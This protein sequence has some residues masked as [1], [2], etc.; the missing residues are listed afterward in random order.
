MKTNG[1]PNVETSLNES[2]PVITAADEELV[3]KQHAEAVRL[4]NLAPGEFLLYLDDTAPRLKMPP[5]RLKAAV[6][7]ILK[8]RK[9]KARK[10]EA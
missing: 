5:A 9:E 2:P 4:A 1:T 10:A 8:D 7:A 6:E 3:R